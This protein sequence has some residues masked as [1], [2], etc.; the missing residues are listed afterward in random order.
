[1]L[2]TLESL[3]SFANKGSYFPYNVGG[4]LRLPAIENVLHERIPIE[5][6]IHLMVAPKARS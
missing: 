1:M 5:A 3:F 4:A 2:S 6:E